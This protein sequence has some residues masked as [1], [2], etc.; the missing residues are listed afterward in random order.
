MNKISDIR[1]FSEG[2]FEKEQRESI[3]RIYTLFS[4]ESLYISE[5]IFSEKTC[6]FSQD[7][8]WDL[9]ISLRDIGKLF[10]N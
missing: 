5:E 9:G 8:L 2:I 6:D 10:S 7:I 3:D 4:R 1:A